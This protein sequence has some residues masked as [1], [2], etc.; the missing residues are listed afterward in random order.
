MT[1]APEKRLKI[2]VVTD[3]IVQLLD[4]GLYVSAEKVLNSGSQLMIYN[5]PSNATTPTINIYIKF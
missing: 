2:A 5:K 3:K 4:S 1:T